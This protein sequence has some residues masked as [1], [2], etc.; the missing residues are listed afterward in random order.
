[1]EIFYSTHILSDI[2][3]LVD[4]LAFLH[5]GHIL[6]RTK[7]EDL[8]DTWRQITFRITKEIANI[9]SAVSHRQDGNDH[10]VFSS[11]YEATIKHLRELGADNIHEIRMSI[12]DIA[13]QI[14]K[15]GKNA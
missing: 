11:D 3:R 1:M 5:D 6:L 7:K 13:V 8:T 14:L 4:E 2:S 15:G 10:Q 9:N 12:E